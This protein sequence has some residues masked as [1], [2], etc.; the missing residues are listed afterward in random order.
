MI[1]GQPGSGPCNSHAC[2]KRRVSTSHRPRSE[3]RGEFGRHRQPDG[4]AQLWNSS[5]TSGQCARSRRL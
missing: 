2:D 1:S 5:D 4:I 3:S